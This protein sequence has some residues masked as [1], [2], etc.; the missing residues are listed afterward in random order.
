V[1]FGSAK[2]LNLKYFAPRHEFL[3]GKGGIDALVIC[4][5]VVPVIK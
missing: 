4:R 2:A 5:F 1:V 3:M